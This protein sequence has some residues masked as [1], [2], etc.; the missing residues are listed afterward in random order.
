[1]FREKERGEDSRRGRDKGEACDWRDRTVGR[2]A[3]RESKALFMRGHIS[4][5]FFNQPSTFHDVHYLRYLG[6]LVE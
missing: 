1:M 5:F 2:L 6:M 3:R 4:L